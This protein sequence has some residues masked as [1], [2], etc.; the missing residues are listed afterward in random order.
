MEVHLQLSVACQLIIL[1]S[2][3]IDVLNRPVASLLLAEL[4]Y[5]GTCVWPL[6]QELEIKNLSD[7]ASY[8]Y[9]ILGSLGHFSLIVL[10]WCF[11]LILAE[12][13]LS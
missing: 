3:M 6:F 5:V 10:L 11:G 2:L 7:S 8:M 1:Q 12:V 4:L 13:L 9:K